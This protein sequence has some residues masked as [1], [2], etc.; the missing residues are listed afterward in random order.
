MSLFRLP[1]LLVVVLA[2]A[3]GCQKSAPPASQARRIVS[4]SPSVTETLFALGAGPQ[5]VGVSDYT[6]LPEGTP[7]LPRVGTTF[8][9]NF[10]AIARL[11]PTLLVD[12]QVK[13]APAEA[14]SALAPLKVLPWLSLS[15]VVGSVKELGRLSD[16]EAQ[17]T[18]LA[19]RLQSTLSR[20]APKDAPRVLL[21]LGD[22]AGTLSEVWY[23]KR[24]SLHGAALESAGARNAIAEDVAGPPNLSLEGLIAVDPDAVLV[25]VTTPRMDAGQ[26]A[27]VL[28]PWKKLTGLRAAREDRVRLVVG[29]DVQ[30]TGPAILDVVER[31]RAAL[32]TLPSAR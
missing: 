27:V 19:E 10:E 32:G 20:P 17:A 29:S 26:Q 18:A 12:Q 24:G 7:A 1:S 8:A 22:A 9:P 16:R 5:V 30:S 3:A 6:V 28:A 25:L 31:L 15:E 23:M 14:L 4:L 21:V 13:Q 2:L 11:K